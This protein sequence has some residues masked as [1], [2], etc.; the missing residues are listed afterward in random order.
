[1]VVRML[2]WRDRHRNA[3]L[4]HH[5]VC[6]AHI[7]KVV[8]LEH[9]VIQP[10]LLRA[11]SK[12]HRVVP[13]VAMHEYRRNDLLAHPNLV[14]DAPAHSELRIEIARCNRVVLANDAMTKA[15]GSGAEATVHPAPRVE[16]F[17]GLN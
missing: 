5:V 12:R 17:V 2:A 16:W 1:M 13:V 6:K 10:P 14:F 7:V 9:D 3:A 11:D 4:A 15:A 8:G